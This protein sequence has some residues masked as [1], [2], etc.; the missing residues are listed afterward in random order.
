ML[1]TALLAAWVPLAHAAAPVARTAAPPPPPRHLPGAPAPAPTAA[2]SDGAGLRTVPLGG[3]VIPFV[4]TSTVYRGTDRRLLSLGV[5]NYSGAI[6][7]A[8]AGLA[9]SL[10]SGDLVGV[11]AS[12]G[13]NLVGGDIDGVQGAAGVNLVR[14]GVDGIQL[15]A[16]A[17]LTQGGVDGIQGAAGFNYAGAAVDG[18]QAAAGL[19][20]AAADV[21]GL[22]A[23]TVNYAGG[24]VDGFQLGLVNIARSVDAPI[25]LVNVVREGRTHLDVWGSE[26]GFVDVAFKHGG[27][28]VHNLYGFGYRP[29][30][31]CREWSMLL[32][33]GGHLPVSER[34][35]TDLDLFTQHVSPTGTFVA[36]P[37][38]LSTLRLRGVLSLGDHVA[39][40]AG[41][42]ANSWVST[43][44]DGARYVPLAEPVA[45]NLE[46]GVF[47]FWPGVSAG[48]QLF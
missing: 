1:S 15:S 39:L 23:A 6:E 38:F 31:G 40:T 43:V 28:F 42:S 30:A 36:A 13:V 46:S 37:N 5:F 12:G 33:I 41:V 32:G 18:I 26:T 47:R 34:F 21:D 9:G 7:G 3:D 11:Q 24:H 22:Q 19:N 2:A 14:G 45:A 4:G 25:G 27:T 48:V 35:A 44:H 17:N 16:G 20:V 10:V 29:G 8:D